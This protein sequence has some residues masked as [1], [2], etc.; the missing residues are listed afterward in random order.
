MVPPARIQLATPTL[1]VWCSMLL[2]YEGKKIVYRSE[3]NLRRCLLTPFQIDLQYTIM[4][5]ARRGVEPLSP[6]WKADELADIRTR[7][8]YRAPGRAWT[9]DL[10]IMSVLLLTYWA[11]GAFCC[12]LIL[13]TYL[14]QL[15]RSLI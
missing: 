14:N 4:F 9:C 8:I 5:V 13:F 11:T 10:H 3:F 2:S 6:A 7:H 1:E 15:W 12:L